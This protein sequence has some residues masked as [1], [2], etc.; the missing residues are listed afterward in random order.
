M[1]TFLQIFGSL[2][3][4][5]FGM[6][7][8]SDGL[9]RLSGEKLR[10]I[11]RSMTSNRFK[12]VASGVVITTSVQSSAVT[13]LMVV[14]FVNA[15]LL[16]LRESIGVI[17]GA[18][19]GTTTSA[20]AIALLG[21]KY[22][23]STFALPMVGL[24]VVMSFVK[25][26]TVKNIGEFITGLAL[27]LIG[28]DLLK[29]SVPDMNA[30]PEALEFLRYYSNMGYLSVFLFLGL[31]V[32]ATVCFQSS[33]VT[34]AITITMA[35]KGW[36]N[37][38]TAGAIVLGENIGTTLTANVAA[39]TASWN[40]KRAAFAHF[41]F[42]IIGVVWVLCIFYYFID[43]IC[44]LVPETQNVAPQFL[45]AV[46]AE[47]LES[48][49][50][51]VRAEVM[52]RAIIPERL[53]MFHTLF[54]GLNILLLIWFVPQ[55]EKITKW[56][57]K[58]TPNRKRRTSLQRIDFLTANM[59]EMGELALFEGQ[60]ELSKL[61][62]LSGQ[63][64]NGFV[65]IIQNPDKDLSSE[66]AKL[67]DLEEESDKI[68][69]A[70]TNFFVQCSSHDLSQAGVKMVTRN[71]IIVPELEEMCDACYRLIT[72]ARKRYRKQFFDAILQSEVFIDFCEKMN[73]FVDYADKS[74][75][76]D[77]INPED[78]EM[79][80]HMRENLDALRKSLRREAIGQMEAAGV[81][82]GG[83]L[84]I[85]ILSACERV[86]SHAM[87]ILEAMNLKGAGA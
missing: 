2:G 4:F 11:M 3:L 83:I 85:E 41:L 79:W 44:F 54:N 72:L 87:N 50:P 63:M 70:L 26:P 23:I 38:E 13:T 7:M 40:S 53:A 84:F 30:H 77:G 86:N 27:L 76:K 68:A 61:A 37:I 67:R 71:M 74:L 36:I 47:N 8:L 39:L 21:F 82:K 55:L 24:G 75:E 73:T 51:E 25:K 15:G 10:N 57:Y 1:Y 20:W 56:V 80:K 17:M 46:G 81:T 64:F 32:L 48:L 69:H 9:Q 62:E 34:M 35:A 49:T 19:L 31:G 12:G 14:G 78:L 16:T 43:L 59:S 22:T 6:K 45:Q 65:Y 52:K 42:N 66:V 29:N 60:K 5:L 58:D 33:A 28:L 18:N